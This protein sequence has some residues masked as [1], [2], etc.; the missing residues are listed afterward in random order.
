MKPVDELPW[1][2][3]TTYNNYHYFGG[4]CV[5]N[6]DKIFSNIN[7]IKWKYNLECALVLYQR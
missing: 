7:K 6:V 2:P 3:Y 5:E 1:P 4:L